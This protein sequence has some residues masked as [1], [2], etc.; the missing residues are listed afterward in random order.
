MQIISQCS[1][2]K[3]F[4]AVNRERETCAAF[5]DGIPA[6]VLNNV[7]DHRRPVKGDHGIRYER[8]SSVPFPEEHPMD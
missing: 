1:V 6:D 5:P 4:N 7:V 3:H 8:L 2:C